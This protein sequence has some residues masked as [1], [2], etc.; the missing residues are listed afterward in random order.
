MRPQ[1]NTDLDLTQ[2]D[3][4]REAPIG[5]RVD[6]RFT[7]Q[8]KARHGLAGADRSPDEA[9]TQDQRDSNT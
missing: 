7:Q 5:D 1:H 9:A 6:G 2:R 8:Y 4:V 3:V